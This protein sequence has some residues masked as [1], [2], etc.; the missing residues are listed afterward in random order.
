MSASATTRPHP[1]GVAAEEQELPARTLPS[2]DEPK[3]LAILRSPGTNHL[4][5][6]DVEL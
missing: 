3:P 1:P 4:V 6:E 5:S 2:G